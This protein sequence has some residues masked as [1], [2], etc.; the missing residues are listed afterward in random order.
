M[1]TGEILDKLKSLGDGKVRLQNIKRGGREEQFGVKMGDIRKLAAKIKTDHQLAK[2]LWETGNVEARLLATLVFDPK[3]FSIAELDAL[4][5]SERSALI[6]DWLYSYVIKEHPDKELMRLQWLQDDDVMSLR[7]GWSLTS[8]RVVRAPEGLDLNALLNQI[9]TEMPS[10]STEVQW[11]MNSTLAQIGINFANYRQ[12]A[13]DI[14]ERLGIYRNFPVSKGC[15][16]PFAPIW[17]NEMVK[18]QG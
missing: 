15:T 1:T 3:A 12:R 7:L 8:G 9:E 5:K 10:A 16:S 13:L 14:G 2:T 18:R 6:V 11:T 4:V 17:I